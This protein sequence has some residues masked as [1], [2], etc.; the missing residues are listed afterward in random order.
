VSGPGIKR[1][2]KQF[3]EAKTENKSSESIGSSDN[4]SFSPAKTSHN[5]IDRSPDQQ[6]INLDLLLD[7]EK[8]RVEGQIHGKE[9]SGATTKFSEA[10]LKE[11]AN[12]TVAN[13]TV[14]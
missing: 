1:K 7:R 3:E 8:I 6:E 9:G 13:S 12:Q 5:P 4:A 14:E 2:R 11:I 10:D